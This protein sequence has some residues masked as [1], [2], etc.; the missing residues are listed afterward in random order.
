MTLIERINSDFLQARKSKNAE[1][2]L[3]L[4]TLKG[5]IERGQNKS[6]ADS[7]IIPVI[8]KMV[9][10]CNIT[11]TEQSKRESEY[12]IKYLPILLNEDEIETIVTF[13]ISQHGKTFPIIMKKFQEIYKGKADNKLVSQVINKFI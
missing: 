8:K 2:T 7:D 10:N 4:S 5:E 1:I 13:L 11:N 9:D 3:L 12:L 6:L